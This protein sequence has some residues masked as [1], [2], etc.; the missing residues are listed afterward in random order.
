MKRMSKIFLGLLLLGLVACDVYGQKRENPE[1]AAEQACV[2]QDDASKPA[3]KRQEVSDSTFDPE[4]LFGMPNEILAQII[5]NGDPVDTEIDVIHFIKKLMRLREVSK[6]FTLFRIAGILRSAGINLNLI[7]EVLSHAIRKGYV[8]SVAILL[9]AGANAN[10]TDATGKTP[11]FDAVMDGRVDCI[12]IL[13]RSGAD[14]N[15]VDYS[16]LTVLS[17]AANAGELGALDI[18][19]KLSAELRLGLNVD[20]RDVYDGTALHWAVIGNRPNFLERLLDLG[21]DVTIESRYSRDFLFQFSLPNL[22]KKQTAL[23]FAVELEE[24]EQCAK[25]LVAHYLKNGIE[26]PRNLKSKLRKMG[27]DI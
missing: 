20:N 22:G 3:E 11:L 8:Y 19:L 1:E 17:C 9:G 24:R 21:A 16:G 23:A 4:I 27:F 14:V 18:L 26:I 10:A 5:L 25:I 13:V 2:V 6:Q 15:A 7:N 12:E